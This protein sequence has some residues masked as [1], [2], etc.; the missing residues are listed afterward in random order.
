MENSEDY[1]YDHIYKQ[2]KIMGYLGLAVLAGSV[3]FTMVMANM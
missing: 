3:V 1:K 2:L